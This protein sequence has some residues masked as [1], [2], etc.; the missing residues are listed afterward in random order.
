MP[1]K[2][3]IDGLA[4]LKSLQGKELGS[5]PWRE[6]RFEDIVKFAEVTGDHQWIHVDRE[7][8]KAG[9]FGAPIAHGYF[10]LSLIAG[11]FFEMVDTR[12]FKAVLNYGLGKVRFPT[13]LRE[14]KR[15]RLSLK[16]A[17]VKDASGGLD[18][19]F[20]AAV[21]VEGEQKPTCAAELIYRFIG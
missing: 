5:S 3:I 4:G 9:P 8:A 6:M 21:E 2:V 14:G 20:A 13:P 18:A 12:G 7:R 10:T 19:T 1:D 17:E 15:Y 11:L 16:L